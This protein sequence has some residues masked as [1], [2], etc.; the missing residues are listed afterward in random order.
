VREITVR[1]YYIGANDS[2][3]TAWSTQRIPFEATDWLLVLQRQLK[4]NVSEL[5]PVDGRLLYAVYRSARPSAMECVDVEN[6]L[7]Y[8]V[9]GDTLNAVTR[10]GLVFERSYETPGDC[11]IQL[12]SP[13]LHSYE[14]SLVD[15]RPSPIEEQDGRL[16]ATLSF[17]LA[18]SS[19]GSCSSVWHAVKMGDVTLV[20]R[21]HEDK[22]WGISMII[23]APST[24]A[25]T[26]FKAVKHLVDGIASA[27]HCYNGLD[28][29]HLSEQLGNNLGLRDGKAARSLLEDDRHA[30]FGATNLLYRYGESS[31]VKWNPRD[32]YC[33]F[34]STRC[35]YG[36]TTEGLKITARVFDVN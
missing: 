22:P 9:L 35:R 8:N 11:P 4:S 28:I 12:S 27:L 19:L 7:I 24:P 21:C 36:L 31:R 29:D 17:K 3:V 20:R 26:C 34:C 14:Y 10:N 16:L 18:A 2:S 5:S 32:E 30:L 13:A 33:T 15:D 6:L 25:I 1:P 23:D